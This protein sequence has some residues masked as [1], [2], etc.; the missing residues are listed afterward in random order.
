MSKPNGALATAGHYVSQQ[1]LE[2]EGGFGVTVVALNQ[3]LDNAMLA[4]VTGVQ[5]TVRAFVALCH[6]RPECGGYIV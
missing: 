2:T 6:Q 3:P 5:G 1:Q 4:A